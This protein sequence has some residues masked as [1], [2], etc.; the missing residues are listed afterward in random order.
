MFRPGHEKFKHD[1][2]LDTKHFKGHEIY[3]NISCH[4]TKADCEG[5]VFD[6]FFVH[7]LGRHFEGLFCDSNH[8]VL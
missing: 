1:C 3:N 8:D 2:T 4:K 5:P 7:L 6:I